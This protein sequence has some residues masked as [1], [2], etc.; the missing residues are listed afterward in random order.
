MKIV[1]SSYV[2]TVTLTIRLLKLFSLGRCQARWV[3]G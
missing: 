2:V 1:A 3:V